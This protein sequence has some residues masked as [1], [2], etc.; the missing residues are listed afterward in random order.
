[1]GEQN[2]QIFSYAI[3]PISGPQVFHKINETSGG[4]FEENRDTDGYL[5]RQYDCSKSVEGQSSE[6]STHADVLVKEIRLHDQF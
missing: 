5:P 6:G 1:M 4:P 3:R 2:I